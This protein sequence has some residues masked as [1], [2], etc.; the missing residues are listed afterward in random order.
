MLTAE[1]KYVASYKKDFGGDFEDAEILDGGREACSGYT[2]YR[3]EELVRIFIEED[4]QVDEDAIKYLC[5]KYSKALA[6]AKRGFSD[7]N[8]QV[9]NR[10]GDLLVVKPGTYRSPKG[11][12]D[13]YWERTTPNGGTIANDFVT[14]APAGV[15]V[16]IRKS[17]GGFSSNECGTWLRVD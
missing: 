8:Y 14:N 2:D 16:T 9:G 13:C 17:D 6:A 11:T 1:E 4:F 3:G 15:T 10:G 12:T 5:P 7:G